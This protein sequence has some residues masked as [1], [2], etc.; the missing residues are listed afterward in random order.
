MI[1]LVNLS[2][3]LVSV[4]III[5][6]LCSY[7]FRKTGLPDMLFLI[8]LGIA[9][10]P[11]LKIIHPESVVGI[12]S[13][14]GVLAL[15]II[16]FDGGINLN[17][18]KIFSEAPRAIL[19]A[20]LN[21]ILSVLVTAFF[22][23]YLMGL[24]LVYGLL[25][26]SII[27]GTSSIIVISM[28]SRSRI[29]EKCS[30][31]LIL[32]STLSDVL[33]IIAVLTILN[34]IINP[35]L[36]F[37][38]IM[39]DVANTFITGIA[40]GLIAGIF[41]IAVLVKIKERPYSYMLTLAMIFLSYAVSEILGG[42]GA[43]SSLLFGIVIGNEEIFLRVIKRG[44]F[45]AFDR[46]LK[47][48]ETE[49][50]FLIRTFFFVYIGL[51]AWVENFTIIF[52]G[53]I[54]SLILFIIRALAVRISIIKSSLFQ[55]RGL[56]NATLARGL[57]AV[58]LSLL[59]KQFDLPYSDLYVSLAFVVI[60]TTTII[61]TIGTFLARPKAEYEKK[62]EEIVKFDILGTH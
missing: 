36:N 15:V 17:L 13:Y 42:S 30:T 54:L 31:T 9:V 22:S 45:S 6:S 61:S 46:S 44:Q 47:R 52:Y 11:I 53:V 43:L 14:I 57:A 59:P 41:W 18:H 37:E 49:I 58:V 38:A 24:D 21:F 2:F 20:L 55:E 50:A 62:E 4:I 51:I 10:G 1:E 29:S 27:G 8:F 26:G 40:I 33:C 19:L 60:L 7:L 23:R 34:F 39:K 56:M 3:F 5:G 28:V 12:A 16:L 48:I 32:E 25:L 35:Q